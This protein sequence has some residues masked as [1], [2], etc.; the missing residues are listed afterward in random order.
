MVLT[1]SLLSAGCSTT[2]GPSRLDSETL[3][4]HH[5]I[6]DT[7]GAKTNAIALWKAIQQE[8]NNA[9]N[10]FRLARLLLKNEHPTLAISVLDHPV[11]REAGDPQYHLLLAVAWQR[12]SHPAMRKIVS[13][14]EHGEQLF[15]VNAQIKVA[16]AHAYNSDGKPELALAKFGDALRLKPVPEL[17]LSAY[18]GQVASLRKLGR[19]SE[20]EAKLREARQLFPGVDNYL[21]KA[22]IEAE[23]ERPG[24]AGEFE[25]DG[26]HPPPHEREQ[27]VLKEIERLPKEIR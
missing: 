25:D 7:P 16:L 20:A 4:I 12:Y 19:N 2:P 9:E 27:R 10:R 5:L 18:V 6:F 3:D 26:V 14:L 11:C 8:P 24:F 23:L 17:Q 22:R 1:A 15:S 13:L 21:R